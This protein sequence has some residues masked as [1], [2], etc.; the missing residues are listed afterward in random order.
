MD[1]EAHKALLGAL[2]ARRQGDPVRIDLAGRDLR[3][4]YAPGA[5]LVAAQLAGAK[6]QAAGLPGA[7]MARADLSEV[8]LSGCDLA[9]A[10]L[11]GANLCGADLTDVLVDD[12]IFASADLRGARFGGILGEP[13]S[14]AAAR[15]DRETIERSGFSDADVARLLARGVTIDSPAESLPPSLR[16][17]HEV[18][19]PSL[20]LSLRPLEVAARQQIAEQDALEMPASLRAF[21]ELSAFIEEARRAGQI[22]LPPGAPSEKPPPTSTDG[23]QALLPLEP[24]SLA[25]LSLAPPP[26]AA[27]PD[28]LLPFA[29]PQVGEEYLG[30]R[31]QR[32]LGS[33][34]LTATFLGVTEEG[35]RVV[36]RVFDPSCPGAALQL[37]AFQRGVRALNRMQGIE[38]GEGV[39][40][41]IAV[42]A[43]LT[44]Y[45]VRFSD[46]GRLPDLVGVAISLD[47]KLDLFRSV[48]RTVGAL[49]REGLLLRCVRPQDILVDGLEPILGE[50][51]MV[52]LP[53]LRQASRDLFGYGGYAAPEEIIGQGTRSPTADVYVLGQLL[54]Y[55]L[56]AGGP[57]PDASAAEPLLQVVERATALDPALRYQYVDELVTDLDRCVAQGATA[58]LGPSHRPASLSRLAARPMTS[59]RPSRRDTVGSVRTVREHSARPDEEGRWLSPVL[60]RGFAGFGVAVAALI[61]LGIWLRPTLA[62]TLEG[63]G[64]LPAALIGLAAWGLP[65]LP[66]HPKLFRWVS[67]AVLAT[68]V[69]LVDLGTIATLRWRSDLRSGSLD[70]KSEAV[71][72]LARLGRRGFSRADLAGVSLR[73]ADL[74]SADFQEASLK[75]SDLRGAFLMEA[76]F[77]GADVTDADF[78]AADLRGAELEFAIGVERALC[79]RTTR[80]PQDLRCRHGLLVRIDG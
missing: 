40:S 53:A 43:D 26:P 74:G 56:S 70:R 52:D 61:G 19:R 75:A 24:S 23:V 36:A 72:H 42:A 54:R 55:M 28:D 32:R 6:L 68:A 64:L 79:D 30:V 66:S 22:S 31:L 41:L 49:H 62:L 50:I 5:D 20:S 25:P 1:A 29:L 78:T 73:S 14:L 38:G 11:T 51:D 27:S 77:A 35:Q 2:N 63:Y 67:W 69:F 37:P 60:E 59:P 76:R 65:G 58:V 33:D 21:R 48:C 34:T 80:L 7:R 17:S 15:M 46:G 47:G 18:A 71:A 44:G 10:D 45:L 9:G 13:L 57:A 16:G 4:L 39:V 3:G 12:A 8:D